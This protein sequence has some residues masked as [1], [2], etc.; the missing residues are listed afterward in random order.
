[1]GEIRDCITPSTSAE[2]SQRQHFQPPCL[3][4]ELPES[5]LQGG[6]G[7]F[8]AAARHQALYFIHTTPTFTAAQS[9]ISHFQDGR[10]AW[11]CLREVQ[12]LVTGHSSQV[13]GPRCKSGLNHKAL[14]LFSLLG[15]PHIRVFFLCIT[16]LFPHSL[17]TLHSLFLFTPSHFP[18]IKN[19]L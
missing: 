6:A 3:A 13:A 5:P 11:Q 9:S 8:L 19:Q 7:G 14:I 16:F 10:V 18:I 15:Q 17:W 1:M 4:S 12:E 2:N